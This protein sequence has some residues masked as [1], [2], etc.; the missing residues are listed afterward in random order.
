[1][2]IFIP[3]VGQ[4][5]NIGDI[6]H[7]RELVG[8][9]KDDYKLKVYVGSAP[10]GFIEA[11]GLNE[12]CEI[13]TSLAAWLWAIVIS[14][15]RK[16]HFVF[17]PGEINLGIKRFFGELL[18]LPF[19]ILV[20]LKRGEVI[21]VGV[22]VMSDSGHKWIGVMRG[23]LSL[24]TKTFWRTKNS[25]ELF[26]FGEVIP[27]LAFYDYYEDTLQTDKNLITISLRG[28]RPYPQ[29]KWFKAVKRIANDY[30]LEVVTLAQVRM[31]NQAALDIAEKFNSKA[32]TW[33]DEVSHLEQKEILKSLYNRSRVTISDRLHVLIDAYTKMSVP[34]NTI[35]IQS[36]KVDHHFEVV[37]ST[38]VSLFLEVS[39]ED[40]I[41]SFIKNAL[42]RQ[43]DAHKE[44]LSDSKNRLEKV[45]S[46]I[47][48]S[49]K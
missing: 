1:M 24:S 49:F 41:Y 4:F 20:R 15:Y 39:S 25:Q 38:S 8:W 11:L 43:S 5:T 47:I 19:L 28:M 18:L 29:D 32:Y 10:E 40:E 27:D 9:L 35:S 44:I 33:E 22:A 17:N 7:R 2:N 12:N 42:D 21:R 37:D 26:G 30:N 36:K 48:Q 31:D 16:T 14:G 23:L 34:V 46:E 45:K 3:V 13:Y 6:L